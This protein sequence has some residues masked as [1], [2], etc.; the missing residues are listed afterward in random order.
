MA[1][2]DTRDKRS[3]AIGLDGPYRLVLPNADGSINQPDRQHVAYTYRGISAFVPVI[4]AAV[5]AMFQYRQRRV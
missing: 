4:S 5:R 1:D 2:L 3:S